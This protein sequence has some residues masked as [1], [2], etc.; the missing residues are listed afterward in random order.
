MQR[1]EANS[2]VL[3]FLQD[4]EELSVEFFF[5]ADKEDD[6]SNIAIELNRMGYK[7]EVVDRSASDKR[8][9]VSGWTT[10]IKMDV[11]NVTDWTD[12]MEQLAEENNC[13]FD[14]WGTMQDQDDLII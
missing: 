4:S 1:R 10:K 5:Y 3:D 8:W 6:A 11:D 2:R 13:E 14:G 12:R 7:I 9:C